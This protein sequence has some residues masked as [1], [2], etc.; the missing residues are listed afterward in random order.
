MGALKAGRKSVGVAKEREDAV[1]MSAKK[2]MRR[3]EVQI[4]KN[5]MSAVEKVPFALTAGAGEG[6]MDV[7]D[8]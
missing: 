1:L 6:A 3:S 2:M 7:D 5:R 8:N 4:R